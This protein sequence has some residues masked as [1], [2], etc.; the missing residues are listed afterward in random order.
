LETSAKAADERLAK[1]P[2]GTQEAAQA[3]EE[4]QSLHQ[5]A[6]TAR[7]NAEKNSIEASETK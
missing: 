5:A 4:A 7:I 1:A 3:A 2:A 6:E